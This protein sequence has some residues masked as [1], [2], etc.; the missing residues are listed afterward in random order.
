MTPSGDRRPAD[1]RLAPEPAY[2]S[3][4]TLG[5]ERT[6]ARRD[7]SARMSRTQRDLPTFVWLVPL[8][9]AAAYVVLFL[10]RLPHNITALS[11]DSDYASEFTIPETLVHTGTSGN[12]VIAS[13][14]QWVGLWFGL[15]TASLPLHRELWGAAPTILFLL[16]ALT[17]GWSVSQLA[18]RRAATLAVLMGFVTSPLALAFFMAPAH[19][20]V[21]LCTALAGAYLIWLARGQGRR[22]LAAFA[23][24]PLAGVAV[25]TCLSSDLLIAATVLIPLS[26][27]AILAGLRRDRRSRLVALSALTTVVVA[28]PV[29]K[30]TTS[31]MTSLGFHT[32]E[33]P[34]QV[35][36][37][38]ELPQR[39]RLLFK[40]LKELFNGYLGPES[41]GT[42][43]TELGFASTVVMS[44][45]L[46]TLL[47]LGA[48]TVARFAWS[49]LRRSSGQSPTQLARSLHIVYWV[50]SGAVACGAFWLAGD[51]GGGTNLH[52]S[53]YGTVIF[54]VAAV[55]PLLLST[56]LLSRWLI[57]AG[58]AV[59]FAGSLVGLAG[60]N[61][62]THQWV[63]NSESAVL[64][65]AE[66]DHVTVG[67]GG[68][69][70]ASSLTW[71]TDN[72]IEVRP[73]M[74][75][76]NPQGA[77]I[78]PFYMASVPSWYIPRQR[79]TFLL[80]SSEEVWLRG[81]PSGLGKPLAA[82][83]FGP[84]RMYIYPYD[85]ASRLGPQPD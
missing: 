63:T 23:V 48:L 4:G 12:L 35:A 83:T 49:G 70:Q 41:P 21:Y 32:L 81:L 78:C 66:A 29:A 61:L 59:L 74:E 1:A 54:S 24:P 52:E 76:P 31:I 19:I 80:T 44:L 6:G 64:K 50:S 5:H 43:H 8:A 3:G 73:L 71:N 75:C 45:A 40:G 69:L 36:P 57:A 2:A 84:V 67:Y 7:V 34:D 65:I 42:L 53:Y 85:I 58:A 47:V 26:L 38:S 13:S 62:N 33:T 15:L 27:T 82:Y 39:A 9:I 79:E 10:I 28:I 60:A 56:G 46:L 18:G 22:R 51:T 72:R 77:T 55:I 16:T 37:L 30:L 11:W 17:V 25:G 68:Y 14:G 20:T